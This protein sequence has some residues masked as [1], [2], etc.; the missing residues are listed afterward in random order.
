MV[1]GARLLYQPRYGDCRPERGWLG[2][3]PLMYRIGGDQLMRPEHILLQELLGIVHIR[4]QTSTRRKSRDLLSQ[5]LHATLCCQVQVMRGKW[6]RA[7]F[8]SQ[9]MIR[10]EPVSRCPRCLLHLPAR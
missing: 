6:L 1:A 4:W 2:M 3:S 9:V 8:V 7:W 5:H 10:G